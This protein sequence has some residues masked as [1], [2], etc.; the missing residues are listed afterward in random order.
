[1]AVTDRREAKR[2]RIPEGNQGAA[3]PPGAKVERPLD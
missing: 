1:M 2:I 3:L